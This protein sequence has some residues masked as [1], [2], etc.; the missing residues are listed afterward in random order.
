MQLFTIHLLQNQIKNQNKDLLKN[1]WDNFQNFLKKTSEIKEWKEEKYQEGFLKD[2]FQDCLGYTLDTTNSKEFNL[3]REKKNIN[4]S[5]KADGA[6]LVNGNVVGVIELKGQDTKNF[7]TKGK[8]VIE[9]AFGYLTSHSRKFAH[10]VIISNFDEIRFYIDDKLN[11]QSYSLFNLTYEEFEEFHYLL[12]YENIKQNIPLQLKEQQ[13]THQDDISNKIY[14]QYSQLRVQLF[15]N[16]I[17]KNENIDKNILLAKTQKILD[18]MIFIFFAEDR[19]I[20]P[21]DTIDKIIE[22]FKNDYRH[23][24]LYSHYKIYFDAINKGNDRLNISA[25]NGG[26]FA[27][28]EILDNL[29]IDDI[30]L[31]EIPSQLSKYNF[32][33]EIDVN[34][35][36]HI[37]ENSLNDIEELKASINDENFDKTKTKRKKDGVFYTPEYITKYIVE[38]TLGKLCDEK[39]E[40]LG[41]IDINIEIPK[42]PAKLNKTELA[43]EQSLKDYREY[44]LSLKILDPACGSGAFLN[45]A[46]NYLLKEHDFIDESEKVL[47]GGGGL[48]GEEKFAKTDVKKEVLE[49][50]LYGVD[51]NEEA[52]EIAKL[53]LWLRTVEVGRPLTR[54]ADKLKVGNSLIDDKSVVNNAFEWEKE[55]PEVF[56]QGGFDVVIGNPPYVDNRGFDKNIL[57]YY[58]EIYINSFGKSG[59]DNFKTTKFNLI[60]P[61][62]ELTYKLLSNKGLTSFIIHKNIFKTNSYSN[63]RKFI[64]NNYNIKSLTDWGSGQFHDVVAETATFIF[65]KNK[66]KQNEIKIEFYKLCN[67]I[68]ESKELQDIYLKNYD[69]IFSI[70]TIESDRSILIKAKNNSLSLENIVNI[71]NGIVTGNDKKYIFGKKISD[72]LKP[73]IRGKDI[74][75]YCYINPIEYIEY[76]KENLLRARDE[77]IFLANEKLIMQMINTQFII[78]FDNNQIYNLGTTYALTLKNLDFNIKFILSVLSSKFLNWYYKK[79]FTNESELTNAISTKNLFEIP[80]REITLEQQEPFI[81]KADL[82]LELNKKLQETKQNFLKELEL[83]KVSKKLQSF[84]TLEFDE[85]VKE[86]TKAKKIK[87]TKLEERKF[88]EEWQELFEHD[89]QKALELQTQINQTDKEIDT[90]VYELYGLS[91]DEIKIVEGV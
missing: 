74:S 33:T 80:I 63:I 34:I 31:Q 42:N 55:F 68:N 25:Y 83:E 49:H 46:L 53:S 57:K 20:I 59:T 29:I 2:I 10:Y 5:K 32:N 17:E 8:N 64:L 71:N 21:S 14:K 15:N 58:F 51:I 86:F 78:T 27:S 45:Q 77:T 90:M 54:L 28:D 23:E 22:Q 6:I 35:L 13:A 3:E 61:F 52:V 50:N 12:C 89:K 91:E 39:K 4:N 1:R 41:L 38:N 56:V 26:L 9:Q 73:I 16:L 44:L 82:M 87:L 79:Q 18:R 24:S 66:T 47:L 60:A 67:K 84:E 65:E 40:L 37:F 75:K 72:I 48:F 43:I 7:E 62:I 85:F 76:N 81:Q 30:V 19:G 36:G 70:Y 88:K 69:Y 11:Y